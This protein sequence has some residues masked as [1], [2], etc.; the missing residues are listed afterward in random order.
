MGSVEYR[1]ISVQFMKKCSVQLS[2]GHFGGGLSQSLGRH[3]QKRTPQKKYTTQR[4]SINLSNKAHRTQ[5]AT[6]WYGHLSQ[7]NRWAQ[8]LLRK[9]HEQKIRT[10]GR[11]T[12]LTSTVC[13]LIMQRRLQS[14]NM[15]DN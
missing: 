1:P 9:K 6:P 8:I 11:L 3:G 14:V 12:A 15:P 13:L 5:N 7:E 4:N 10:V 2:S